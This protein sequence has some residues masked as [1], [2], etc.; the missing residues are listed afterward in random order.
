MKRTVE[1]G[2]I[3]CTLEETIKSQSKQLIEHTT[4][5]EQ[6]VFDRAKI[7]IDALTELAVHYEDI[8]RQFEDLNK[9]D[10]DEGEEYLVEPILEGV[11]R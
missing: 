11:I 2:H 9:A 8:Q 1:L 7:H 4:Y 5:D 10:A 6:F 3:K